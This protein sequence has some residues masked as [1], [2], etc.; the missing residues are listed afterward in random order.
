LPL[1]P[2]LQLLDEADW[3]AAQ[4]QLLHAFQFNL[5][6]FSLLALLVGLLLMASAV[7]FGFWQ[8]AALLSRL[9]LLGAAPLTLLRA[10][11]GEA[12]LLAAIACLLGW[13]L[14]SAL[15]RLLLPAAA[16]TVN[17]LFSAQSIVA[18]RGAPLDYVKSALL[19]LAATLIANGWLYHR[20]RRGERP[21]R[22]PRWPWVIALALA[23]LAMLRFDGL[24]AAFAAL[25]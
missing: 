13:L 6:A 25:F 20:W 12:L 21:A 10:L 22:R 3:R 18:L 16:A 24:P 9:H 14:G 19:A 7:Q 23:G 11:L 5:S 2:G 17:D 4:Q 1:P 15:S 8:R